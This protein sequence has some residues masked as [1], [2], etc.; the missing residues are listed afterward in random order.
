MTWSASQYS[1][2]L[3][4]RTRA[5][6]DL[7]NAVPLSSP[8]HIVDIGC[9]PGNSTRLLADRFPEAEIVGI[10]SD[11]DMIETARKELPQVSWDLIEVERWTPQ[12]APNLIFANASLQWVDDH[13]L[14]LPKLVGMLATGGCL[15]VQMPDN[16]D[17]PSHVVMR[18]VAAD[19]KWADRLR[20]AS[21]QRKALLTPAQVHALLRPMTQRLDVWR[22]IYNFELANPNAVVEWFKGSALRPFLAPLA[23]DEAREF[24]DRYSTGIAP[25]YPQSSAGTLL[26]FPRFFFVAQAKGDMTSA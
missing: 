22:T 5:A 21:C 8:R 2:F 1:K 16:L 9:G 10:D 4:D 19:P 7:L 3:D 25:F 17:E 15:A 14:L 26:A 13:A 24:L 20:A 12:E 23:E 18:E 6:R 11:P